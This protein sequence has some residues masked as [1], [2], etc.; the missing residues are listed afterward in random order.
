MSGRSMQPVTVGVGPRKQN[1]EI[2]GFPSI[3]RGLYAFCH[4]NRRGDFTSPCGSRVGIQEIRPLGRSRGELGRIETRSGE[5]R[6]PIW[7]RRGAA[8]RIA[9]RRNAFKKQ[10][11]ALGIQEYADHA[12]YIGRRLPWR[13]DA[14]ADRVE[15]IVGLHLPWALAIPEENAGGTIRAQTLPARLRFVVFLN[16]VEIVRVGEESMSGV[17]RRFLES[18]LLNDFLRAG[19]KHIGRLFERSEILNSVSVG[20]RHVRSEAKQHRGD[21]RQPQP[22]LD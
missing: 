14:R 1:P 22:G 8:R 7:W 9:L 16:V 13:D 4:L 12:G 11:P 3:S 19:E 18:K 21:Q 15:E 20:Q 2:N 17:R 10:Q 5:E 6:G